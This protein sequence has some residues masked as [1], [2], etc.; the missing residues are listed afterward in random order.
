MPLVSWYL[1]FLLKARILFLL[2]GLSPSLARRSRRLELKLF[3]LFQLKQLLLKS[4][5]HRCCNGCFLLRSCGLGYSPFARHY[6]GN[7]FLFLFLRVLRCF[8]SPG[9]LPEFFLRMTRH[10]PR[11]VPPFGYLRVFACL[12]L[13]GAFRCLP[14][15]SSALCA[16][17]S[18]MCPLSFLPFSFPH[19]LTRVQGAGLGVQGSGCRA[20]GTDPCTLYPAPCTLHPAPCALTPAP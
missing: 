5:Q 11:R 17:A 10:D 4:P 3:S 7:R 9:A 15:P 2:T 1:G 16:K 6:S 13:A 19:L 20:R 14:R 8:S 12:Q 18:T